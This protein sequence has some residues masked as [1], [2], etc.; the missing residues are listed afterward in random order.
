MGRIHAILSDG[1]IVTDVEAFRRLYEEVRLG[2]VY[3]V[4]KYEPVSS[5]LQRAKHRIILFPSFQ[6]VA[7]ELLALYILV[8]V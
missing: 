3:A 2:W 6:R 7:V 5:H 1:T 4:T 8:A